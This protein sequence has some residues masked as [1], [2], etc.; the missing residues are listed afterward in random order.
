M[1]VY[2][3]TYYFVLEIKLDLDKDL[4]IFLKV[5]IWT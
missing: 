4:K 5:Q 1:R 3:F 2:N